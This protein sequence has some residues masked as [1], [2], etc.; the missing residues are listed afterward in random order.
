M[1][2]LVWLRPAGVGEE[3]ASMVLLSYLS[4]REVV[5]GWCAS[6]AFVWISDFCVIVERPVERVKKGQIHS[7][8]GQKSDPMDRNEYKFR[9]N[10][11]RAWQLISRCRVC[12]ARS[13]GTI[14]L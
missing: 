9:V 1:P 10:Q 8:I 7:K 4:F 12:G 6:I 13:V 2:P 5:A 3:A 14:L 11:G